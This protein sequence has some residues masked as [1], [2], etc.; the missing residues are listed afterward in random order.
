MG[1]WDSVAHLVPQRHTGSDPGLLSACQVHVELP[2]SFQ[3]HLEGSWAV[4]GE[5]I[6]LNCRSRYQQ[7]P[8]HTD[9]PS[10]CHHCVLGPGIA[11]DLWDNVMPITASW[12]NK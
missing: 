9:L 5:C 10:L 8:K 1:V 2:L 12:L 4:K 3:A 11:Q 7:R 6:W